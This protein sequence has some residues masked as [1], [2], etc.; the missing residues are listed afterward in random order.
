VAPLSILAP[1]LAP[2]SRYWVW[3]AVLA[4]GNVVFGVWDAALARWSFAI[5]NGVS[6]VFFGAIAVRMR[7][8]HRNTTAV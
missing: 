1:I 2:Y 8:L 6:A 4:L 3:V 5:L 7:M